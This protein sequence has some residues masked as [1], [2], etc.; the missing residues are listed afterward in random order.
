MAL[1]TT[2]Q[3][4]KRFEYLGLGN[5]NK[6]NLL[7]FQ[8]KAFP[9]DKEE[10]DS[11]YGLHTDR[12]LRTFYNVKKYG[13]G[14]FE[15]Q[16]FRCNCGHCCGYPTF[17]KKVQIEHLAKI[18]KH[19]G[20]PMTIT[21][22]IRCS[23][24]NSRVG[25]VRNSGHT[26]GYATDFYMAG[27][28]DTVA[29]RKSALK[30]IKKQADHEFTYGAYMKDSNGLYRTADSMGNAMHTET[31]AHV[32][33]KQEKACEWAKKIADGGKYKY[34][35]Y[36]SD[37]KTHQCPVCHNLTGKY[38]GWNCIGFA[39][40]SWHHAGIPCKCSCDVINNA[41]WETL[42][43]KASKDGTKIAQNKLG[44]KNVKVIRVKGGG[45]IPLS[46]LKKGDIIAY[47]NGST[48]VHTALYIGNGKIA[49]CTSGRTPN[50]KYGAKS[51]TTMTIKAAI[52][53]T[54]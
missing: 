8:K 14:Y 31:H 51:Y 21:S 26:T 34:K 53:Y 6:K 20:K 52:R 37:V 49:D 48:Y 9:N 39:F 47:F 54:K 15:P 17:M 35:R 43:V 11:T 10:Q 4:K 13:G 3:R 36:T 22:G 50:I 19:Y 29:H 44:T 45:K 5:Y 32:K 18:R 7:K 27:V 30:W 46:K 41:T 16:E 1:L 2:E 24:E 25:G 28:T 23:Y 40:A 38:K 42:R 33:T 12:A